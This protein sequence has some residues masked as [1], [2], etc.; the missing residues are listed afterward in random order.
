[1]LGLGNMM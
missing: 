1:M